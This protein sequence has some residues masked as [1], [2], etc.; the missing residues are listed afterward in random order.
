MDKNDSNWSEITDD[1]AEIKKKIKNKFNE[2]DHI[3][4]LRD[5]L[6]STLENTR[7]IFNNLTTT[8]DST[9]KDE[10]I[11]KETKDLINKLNLEL[12]DLI[13]NSDNLINS[14]IDKS[15][16]TFEEE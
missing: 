6:A 5:S 13:K 11:K 15:E 9:I 10:E 4:D 2:E 1:I 14:I 16:I 3:D 12:S 7:E 8:I